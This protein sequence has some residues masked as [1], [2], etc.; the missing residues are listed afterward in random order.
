MD[1]IK[2]P[3]NQLIEEPIACSQKVRYSHSGF[4]RK[5]PS[6]IT[7]CDFD[8]DEKLIEIEFSDGERHWYHIKEFFGK[9]IGEVKNILLLH[10]DGSTERLSIV[11]IDLFKIKRTNYWKLIFERDLPF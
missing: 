2:I 10:P 9:V 8:K 7:P 11:W 5:I 4:T 3:I 6:G 1:F